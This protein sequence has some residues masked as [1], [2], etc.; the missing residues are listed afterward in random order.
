MSVLS[1]DGSFRV[2]LVTHPLVR[3]LLIPTDR[4]AF[5]S[6]ITTAGAHL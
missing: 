6:R 5:V 2:A 3:E 4:R 1:A